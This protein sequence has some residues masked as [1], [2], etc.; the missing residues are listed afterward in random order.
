[1]NKCQQFAIFM[2]FT[3]LA[4][5]PGILV[6]SATVE[7]L[8][9]PRMER[10]EEGRVTVDFPTI[11]SWQAFRYL[12]AWLPVE[13][14]L[15]G[16]NRPRVGA[17]HLRAET[18]IDFD[19]RTVQISA[20]TVLGMR[21]SE[22]D[23]SAEV[24]ALASRSF[25]G[26][27]RTVPLDVLL[28]L[29]PAD[30][31]I[32]GQQEEA[33][34][35]NF[36][37]PAIRVSES[38]LNLL[39]IDKKPVTAQ[40]DGTQLE[41]VVNTNWKV[42]FDTQGERWY[43]LN[44]GSWQENNYLA[45]G[46]WIATDQLPSDFVQ[47]AANDEWREVQQVLPASLPSESPTPFIISF[48]P[49]ELIL[50]DGPPRLSAI[51]DT[52]LY[53]A[54]NTESDLF[55]YK[56]RWYYLVSGRWFSND[57]LNGA[58]QTVNNLPA[59][60]TQIP[61][62][63]KV[64]HVLFSVPGTRQ[65]KLALIEAAL[66]RRVTVAPDSASNLEVIWAGAPRF[67]EIETTKL[68]RGLNT[69]YQVI[70]HNNFYYLCYEGAWYFSAS[71]E[72]PW[73]V[74]LDIPAEIYRIPATDPAYN[75]TF[76]RLDEGYQADS[77]Y[78]N[79]KYSGGYTGSFSTKVTVVYGT[80]WY[81]PSS[82]FWGPR[83]RP[84]YWHH[85]PTYGHNIGYN[86]IYAGYGGRYGYWGSS[87]TLLMESPTVD[88]THGYGSAWEGPL[89]T[90]PGDPAETAERSLEPFLPA[91]ISDG[92]E[93][94]APA[95]KEEKTQAGVTA[96][97]LYA[98]SALSSNM[99][100]GPGGEVYKHENNEWQQYSDGSWSN[101]ERRKRGYDLQN[102]PQRQEGQAAEPWLPAHKRTLSRGEL[103]RQ[104]LARTEGMENY[105]RYRMQ[106]DY[107]DD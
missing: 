13:V 60:F 34:K 102:Q 21:F 47:L 14:S 91:R 38:P 83:H 22:K 92:T 96:S 50:L 30:F 8:D 104:E 66:P 37:P 52:G 75:V 65:S 29:L 12:Q 106:K 59:V 101:A 88:F 64:G 1:M 97:T 107:G 26:R 11:E 57:D 61:A 45:D 84:M 23:A 42:F 93:K 54:R 71:P 73:Q 89:Q 90:T 86:P 7:P 67:E 77:D 76:V 32:P 80:G 16:D 69:P 49:T 62:D 15:N 28:R 56:A 3:T 98:G 20:P 17:V 94:F 103:D 18:S 24:A 95:K 53:F 25:A 2:V 6:A 85:M 82:V 63:H 40:I 35:L 51:G 48:Q 33:P 70:K 39:S 44:E 9:Y 5:L 43:V 87:T 72:G 99:F 105:A 81:Y 79:Y 100:S 10:F 78:V 55:R 46:G 68:Q 58:W 27:H 36:N 31:E 74:A 41:F 4:T 19:Q